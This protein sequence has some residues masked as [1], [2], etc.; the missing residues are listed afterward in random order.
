VKKN[1]SV[2]IVTFHSEE[3]IE[4][5]IKPF[6]DQE[7]IIV[8]C[9]N[10]HNL[11]SKL[12]KQ[13]LNIKFI[14]SE[15][16]LGYSAGNNL[17]IKSSNHED[18]LILNPDAIMNNESKEKLLNYM[19]DIKD[20]GILCPNLNDEACK[21]F[22][23]ENNFQPITVDWHAVGKGLVSGCAL[24]LN[25]KKLKQDIFFDEKIFIYKE[26]TDL[27]KRIN[28]KNI[29]IYYLPNSTVNHIGSSSHNKSLEFELKISQQFHW[30][31]GN[32]YFYTKH[33]GLF[34][35]LKKW[36]RKYL[37]SLIKSIFYLLIF[38]KKYKIYFARFLGI[39]SAFLKLKA[40]YRPKV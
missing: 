18:V 1:F 2:V 39:S 17:G 34:F 14:I 27:L 21:L 35:A 30:P 12:L 24:L 4:K 25:K 32:V 7:I 33:F 26:D 9:S 36:G 22:S 29:H 15:E 38:N 19:N 10:N 3:I 13:N 37:S 40:W 16:N 31:Y 11:K 23:K 6:F 8:E 20:Y 28:E 5:T